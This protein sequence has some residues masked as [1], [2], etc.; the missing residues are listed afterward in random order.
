MSRKTKEK[1]RINPKECAHD[2][3]WRFKTKSADGRHMMG[4]CDACKS[5]VK[6]EVGLDE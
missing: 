2:G 5:H 6:R 3:L 4:I 1:P